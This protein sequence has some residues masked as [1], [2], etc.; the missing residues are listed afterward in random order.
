[1]QELRRSLQTRDEVTDEPTYAS[2][3]RAF[4]DEKGI[5]W[6]VWE[7]HPRGRDDL[8]P[9]GMRRDLQM[10]SPELAVGWLAFESAGER[11]RYAPIPLGWAERTRQALIEL[12]ENAK[13]VRASGPIWP[14]R[15]EDLEISPQ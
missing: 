11:R 9:P 12:L 8:I 10:V 15:A 13:V 7:V 2:A 4:R 1:V 3:H 5:Y 6:E 14:A